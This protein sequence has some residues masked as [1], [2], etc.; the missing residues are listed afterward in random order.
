MSSTKRSLPSGTYRWVDITTKLGGLVL[1]AGGL[2]AGITS[3]L[4]VALAFAGVL[5]GVSTVFITQNTNE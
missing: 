2:E 5:L 3:A 1:V 4:G